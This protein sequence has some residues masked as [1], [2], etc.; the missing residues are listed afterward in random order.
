M[1]SSLE[2][3]GKSNQSIDGAKWRS[4]PW[5]ESLNGRFRAIL[6]WREEEIGDGEIGSTE[7]SLETERPSLGMAVVSGNTLMASDSG[8]SSSSVSFV[9]SFGSGPIGLA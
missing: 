1:D 8:N 7:S 9:M 3:M 2:S 4:S 6:G 5:V